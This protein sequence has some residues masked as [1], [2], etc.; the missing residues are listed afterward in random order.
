MSSVAHGGE[1]FV[2]KMPAMGAWVPSWP[3]A[4]DGKCLCSV[5][6]LPLEP[7]TRL[8]PLPMAGSLSLGWSVLLGRSRILR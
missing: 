8:G 6:T 4:G 1:E 3:G 7:V 2:G 5:Y